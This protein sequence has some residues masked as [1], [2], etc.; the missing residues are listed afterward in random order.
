MGRVLYLHHYYPALFFA[1]LTFAS[2][3]DRVVFNHHPIEAWSR[4]SF[5]AMVLVSIPILVTFYIFMPI[6]YGISG[7][8][9][10]YNY[11]QWIST[12]KLGVKYQ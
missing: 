5:I 6:C 2:L 1:I 3:F 4:R 8:I 10:N 11:L 7:P 9:A 12:W